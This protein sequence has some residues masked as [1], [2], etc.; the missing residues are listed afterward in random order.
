MK[1]ILITSIAIAIL[2]GLFVYRV[3]TRDEE[4]VYTIETMDYHMKI[5]NIAN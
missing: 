4:R 3:Y 1:S 5:N 2:T